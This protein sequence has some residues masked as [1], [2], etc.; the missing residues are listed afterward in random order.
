[1]TNK[2]HSIGFHVL[3]LSSLFLAS[4]SIVHFYFYRLLFPHMRM[5][6]HFLILQAKLKQISSFKVAFLNAALG[7][8]GIHGCFPLIPPLGQREKYLSFTPIEQNDL[9]RYSI[10]YS[11]H[12]CFRKLNKYM[13]DSIP[14][15]WLI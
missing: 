4:P 15:K 5:V 6:L 7:S 13:L 10:L 9:K 11:M 12:Y 1:M 3:M 2:P 14:K 8:T